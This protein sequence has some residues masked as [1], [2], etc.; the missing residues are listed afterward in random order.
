MCFLVPQKKEPTSLKV[1]L[2]P[3]GTKSALKRDDNSTA[4]EKLEIPT[5]TN[6]KEILCPNA[7]VGNGSIGN[8]FDGIKFSF[9]VEI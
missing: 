8:L 6:E 3:K 4:W 7:I 9:M 1:N 2:L 5:F